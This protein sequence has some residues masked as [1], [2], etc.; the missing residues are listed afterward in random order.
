MKNI[1][2]L[3]DF[4]HY[5]WLIYAYARENNFS[6]FI[7]SEP[8]LDYIQHDKNFTGA[9]IGLVSFFQRCKEVLS[10]EAL[11]KANNLLNILK[12]KKINIKNSHS[13]TSIIKLFFKSFLLRRS[14]SNK[15]LISIYFFLLIFI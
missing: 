8:S 5:D 10:G 13:L 12:L 9:N 1:L 3:R 15:F 11:K 7:D 14:W 2:N 6:W 4:D